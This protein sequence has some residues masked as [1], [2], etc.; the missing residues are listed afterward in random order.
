MKYADDFADKRLAGKTM[1][2][3]VDVKGIKTRSVPELNDDFAKELAAEFTTWMSS[4][5][6]CAKT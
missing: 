6:A 3:E 5:T 2:Y 4:A 1:T